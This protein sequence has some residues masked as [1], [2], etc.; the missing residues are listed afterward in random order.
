MNI[1]ARGSVVFDIQLLAREFQ[2]A[3]HA[4]ALSAFLLGLY[5][6]LAIRAETFHRIVN[7]A[8]G[9]CFRYSDAIERHSE[10]PFYKSYDASPSPKSLTLNSYA[11][12]DAAE[13]QHR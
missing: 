9:D 1:S 12:S 5:P 13:E 6:T 8:D 10:G 2:R 4:I 3:Q 11:T 7:E